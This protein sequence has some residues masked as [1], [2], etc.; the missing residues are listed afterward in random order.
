VAQ[1]GKGGRA[2]FP[3]KPAISRGMFVAS[4]AEVDRFLRRCLLPVFLVGS[5]VAALGCGSSRSSSEQEA[6][7]AGGSGARAASGS[8]GQNGGGT[9][10]GGSGGAS[11]S[12]GAGGNGGGTGGVGG[13]TGGTGAT[14]GCPESPPSLGSRCATIGAHCSYGD[15]PLP[16]CREHFV[17]TA[18]SWTTSSR[19]SVCSAPSPEDCPAMPNT[20]PCTPG[21]RCAYDP[22]I[23]CTCAT[24][25]CGGTGCIDLPQPTFLCNSAGPASC[26]ERIPNAGTVCSGNPNFCS[27]E[28]CGLAATCSNGSWTWGLAGCP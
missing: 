6:D 18:G 21:T 26:P 3:S 11:G 8:A 25:S 13:G 14:I 2:G 23:L 20:D 24:Q 7:T 15:A 28:G 27:Y 19:Y 5:S 17:C 1:L 9:S 12:G 22:G 10:A 4:N 16:E